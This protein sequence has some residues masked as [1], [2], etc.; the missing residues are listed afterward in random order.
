MRRILAL[1][2][3]LTVV[4]V[5]SPAVA[6]DTKI[7]VWMG[8]WWA[9]AAPNV[10]E[11]FN[12]DPANDGYQLVIETFPNNAYVEKIITAILGNSAPDV[13]DVDATFMGA[14]L[15]RNLLVEW[16]PEELADMN[17]EDFKPGIWGA[18]VH[19][20]KVFAI[21]NRGGLGEAFV[22][23]KTLFDQAGVPYPAEDWTLEDYLDIC[24]KLKEKSDGTWY[25][26]G[27]AGSSA[28][29]ANFESSFTWMLYAK[30]GSWLNEDQTKV[31]MNTPEAIAAIQ[32]WKDLFDKGYVPEGSINYTTA[33]DIAPMFYEGKLAMMN[34]S[35]AW[36]KGVKESG[37]NY[38]IISTPEGLGR[39]GGWTFTIPVSTPN[40][41]AAK[42]FIRWF[43]ESDN[44]GQLMIR[45]PARVSSTQNYEPWNGE[46]Y[47]VM[48]A[49]AA[50]AK[51]P[52][53][54]PEWTELRLII[55][56]EM[57]KLV[58]GQQT[59]EETANAITE[60]GDVLLKEW[61]GM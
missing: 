60:Q 57:Q 33:N 16:T 3:I 37:V 53:T 54:V 47:E 26:T 45:T 56:S 13:A 28:D 11:A 9:D 19:G 35:D 4:L 43:T 44:L 31:T 61:Q 25:P 50:K 21:P 15:R 12:N 38:Q 10:M 14:L 24:A 20:G 49:A 42:K 8:S 17:I 52:P 40:P 36:V 39:T 46:D 1:L 18:G 23:N 34:M 27:I 48:N 2:L 30:G 59:A 6:E 22:I 7:T 29:P 5:S 58:M 41:D 55:I 51:A 32:M